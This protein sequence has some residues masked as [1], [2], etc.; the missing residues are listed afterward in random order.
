MSKKESCFIWA[1]W[2]KSITIKIWR[3]KIDI[4]MD[5]VCPL[6]KEVEESILDRFWDSN[7]AQRA[8][9]LLLRSLIAYCMMGLTP[10]SSSC[11]IVETRH[12]WCQGAKTISQNCD[13]L[14][15]I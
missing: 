8:W 9:S 13:I 11:I 4:L 14:V 1:N 15:S 5:R 12:F 2:I 3:A 6:C 10:L 7:H